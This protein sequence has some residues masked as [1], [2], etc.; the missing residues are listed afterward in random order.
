MGPDFNKKMSS[1]HYRKSHCGDKTVVLLNQPSVPTVWKYKSFATTH[2]LGQRQLHMGQMDKIPRYYETIG[3]DNSTKRQMK[4]WALAHGQA[5]WGKSAN[6]YNVTS[7]DNSFERFN[8]DLKKNKCLIMDVWINLHFRMETCA[9]YTYR[10]FPICQPRP[11][12]HPEQT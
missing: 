12:V 2:Y 3:L 5:I 4:I 8:L 1:H 6:D 9:R 11:S 10:F 7:L